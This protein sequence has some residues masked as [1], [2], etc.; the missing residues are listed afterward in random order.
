MVGVWWRCL[1]ESRRISLTVV[2]FF[3]DS[4]IVSHSI[5][6]GRSFSADDGLIQY[7]WAAHSVPFVRAGLMR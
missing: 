5:L 2:L 7:Q 4:L 1:K 3:V 6:I